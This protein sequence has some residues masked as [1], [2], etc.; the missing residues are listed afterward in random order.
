MR[1][2][3]IVRIMLVKQG[4]ALG[5]DFS[6]FAIQLYFQEVIYGI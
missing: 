6:N 4:W 3:V 5:D 2:M 1:I